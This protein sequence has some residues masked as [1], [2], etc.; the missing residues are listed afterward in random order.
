MKERGGDVQ[1][2]KSEDSKEQVAQKKVNEKLENSHK[3]P[4]VQSGSKKTSGPNR[5]ST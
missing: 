5:P 3:Q 1:R 4:S 2:V